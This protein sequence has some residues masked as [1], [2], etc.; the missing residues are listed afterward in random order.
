MV[1]TSKG[2]QKLTRFKQ[3]RSNLNNSFSFLKETLNSSAEDR[4]KNAATI[5]AFE[6]TFELCWKTLKD[7]LEYQGIVATTPREVLKEAFKAA[8]LDDGQ[9]W[10]ELLDHRNELVHIYNEAQ[11]SQATETIR[12]RALNCIE[13]LVSSLNKK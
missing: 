10:I 12:N 1:D 13:K 11:A 2:E 9:I 3:R 7:Y 5:K 6:M 8:L 4:I